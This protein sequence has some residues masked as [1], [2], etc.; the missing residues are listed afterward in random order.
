[1]NLQL[2]LSTKYLIAFTTDEEKLYKLTGLKCLRSYSF[3][4]PYVDASTVSTFYD[5][6]I[7]LIA[8]LAVDSLSFDSPKVQLG[9]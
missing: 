5:L 3:F 7:L 1:M 4:H 9:K 2:F 6:I 8:A